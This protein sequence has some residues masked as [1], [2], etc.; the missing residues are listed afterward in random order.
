MSPDGK[1]ESLRESRSQGGRENFMR[2]AKGPTEEQVA[3]KPAEAYG[4]FRFV[5]GPR[6]HPACCLVR[7]SQIFRIVVDL[8]GL[9]CAYIEGARGGTNFDTFGLMT[10]VM[11]THGFRH[12]LSTAMVRHFSGVSYNPQ[13]METKKDPCL[14]LL[15]FYRQREAD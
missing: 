7:N 15:A 1:E 8:I 10:Q 12:D 6:V 14:E 3:N 11:R 13:D 2:R 4:V 9:S 5:T